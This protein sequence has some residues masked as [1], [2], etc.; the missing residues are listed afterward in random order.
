M[1]SLFF[2]VLVLF[3]ITYIVRFNEST[4]FVFKYILNNKI[5]IFLGKISYGIYLYHNFIPTLLNSKL[6]N[7]YINPFLPDLLYK[8]YWGYLFLFENIVLLILISW[9]SFMLIEKR[10]LNLKKYFVY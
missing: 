4:F 8:E 5:L 6:I 10:F 1:T 3:V 9:L 7:I 2:I